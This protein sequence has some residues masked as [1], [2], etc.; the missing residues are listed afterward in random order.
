M[1]RAQWALTLTY[2]LK[3]IQSVS[4]DV[5]YFMDYIHL[6]HKYNTWATTVSRSIDQR[7]MSHRPFEFLRSGEGYPNVSRSR[8]TI[9]S[10]DDVIK[11][12]H[13]PLYW[14]FVRGIRRSSVNSPHKGQWRG[15][16]VFSLICAWTNGWVNNRGAGGLDAIAL[17]LTS[18]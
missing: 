17:I 12:K 3:V 13:F 4:C 2:I 8:S 7:T 5:A 15:A 18:L 16:F 10:H 11:W 6:W 9:S 14:P 1:C